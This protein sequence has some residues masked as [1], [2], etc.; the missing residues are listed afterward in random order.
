MKTDKQEILA[1]EL[2]KEIIDFLTG[3]ASSSGGKN[4]GL[5]CN[6]K[7]GR[8]SVLATS[9]E[10]VPRAT[11][12]DYFSDGTLN[13]WFNAEPGGKI[14]NIMRN[15]NVSVGIFEPVDH[16]IDQK[17]LQLWGKAQIINE[18][19]NAALFL[20]K[21]EVFGVSEAV[22]GMVNSM[23]HKKMIPEEA[24]EKTMKSV[25]NKIN[26][27]KVVPEKIVLREMPLGQGTHRK[28]W[29]NGKAWR[30]KFEL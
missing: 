19:N 26:F 23:I 9:Y 5:G 2:E 6:L 7:H 13:V 30:L 20:E 25:Q 17:S 14:A 3:W 16:T 27:I 29:E 18:K 15:P 24:K 1:S 21:W 10:D 22:A 11:P 12:I 4:E 8:A 28:I